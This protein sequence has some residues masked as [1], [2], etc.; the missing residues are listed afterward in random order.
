MSYSRKP[1]LS[2][3][4]LRGFHFPTLDSSLPLKKHDNSDCATEQ[5]EGL[6]YP[7]RAFR[8]SGPTTRTTAVIRVGCS[9]DVEL[10]AL[11]CFE[12]LY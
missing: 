4:L 3:P 5:S 12:N 1:A 9:I 7:V 10:A 8:P 6:S 11:R 2:G